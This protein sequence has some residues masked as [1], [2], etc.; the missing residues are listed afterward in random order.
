[1][2]EKPFG[3]RNHL[4]LSEELEKGIDMGAF[5]AELKGISKSKARVANIPICQCPEAEH[6]DADKYELLDIQKYGLD[7]I[8]ELL[9]S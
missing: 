3:P 8:H 7:N 6:V 4:S 9:R 1:M 2:G 5:F